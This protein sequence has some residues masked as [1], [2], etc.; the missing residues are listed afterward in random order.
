MK[1]CTATIKG[2]SKKVLDRFEFDND[3][4]GI[5]RFVCRVRLRG[6][7]PAIALFESTGNYWK[8]LHRELEKTAIKPVLVNPYDLKVI[9]LAKFK[10]D[11]RDSERLSDLARG[12]FYKPSY[13]PSE[14]EMDLHELVR[15]R[16]DLRYDATK[17]KNHAH[18]ILVKYPLKRPAYLYTAKGREWLRTA[19]VR[20]LRPDGA[21]RPPGHP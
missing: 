15:T 4:H 16:L 8:V 19:P 5:G 21:R 14:K 3:L 11:N 17:R 20:G 13:V 12:D 7:E 9:T 1:K 6:Y 10:D 18:A 2:R